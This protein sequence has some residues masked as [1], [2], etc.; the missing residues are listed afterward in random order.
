MVYILL[1]HGADIHYIRP[2]GNRRNVIGNLL[3]RL[4]N[5]DYYM[6]I[7]EDIMYSLLRT[8]ANPHELIKDVEENNYNIH[9]IDNT[10]CSEMAKLAKDFIRSQLGDTL[11]ILSFDP[12]SYMF[13]LPPEIITI[14]VDMAC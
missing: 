9:D 14:I 13:N 12:K 10:R 4:P 6:I 5:D 8:G 1:K 7:C 11:Y 2:I 3:S